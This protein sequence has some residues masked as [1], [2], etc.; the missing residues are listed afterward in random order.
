MMIKIIIELIL[1]I[2]KENSLLMEKDKQKVKYQLWEILQEHKKVYPNI[3]ETN[4]INR[5]LMAKKEREKFEGLNGG[6]MGNNICKS[7]SK[8]NIHNN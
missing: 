7:E 6:D 3:E 2:Q 8:S 5:I 1:E 4:N